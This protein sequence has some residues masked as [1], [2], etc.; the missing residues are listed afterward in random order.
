[1]NDIPYSTAATAAELQEDMREARPDT[2]DKSALAIS[3]CIWAGYFVL[4]NVLSY[5][6]SDRQHV[7]GMLMVGRA[8]ICGT[9]I[10]LCL[11]MHLWLRRRSDN[12]PWLLLFEA[13]CL[14][15][16][17]ST[18]LVVVGQLGFRFF[19]DYYSYYPA[20]WMNPYY[21]GWAFQSHL[22]LFVTWCALYVGAVTILWVRRQEAQLAAAQ[23]AAHRAQLLALR[24]QI[25]PHF[26]FNTLNTLAGLIV[27][28]RKEESE[29]IVLDLSRFL[30]H[31]L[32]KTPTELVPL[33]DEVGVLRMY[34][35]IERARF[36]DRLQ[37][38]YDVP[39][40]CGRALVPSLVLLPFAENSIKHAL[41]NSEDGI[42]I[43][44]GARREGGMLRVWLEDGGRGESHAPDGLGIGLSNVRQQLQALY[45]P[46][47]RL[48]AGPTGDGWRNEIAI[49]WQ[50]AA[51]A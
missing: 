44:V 45:G 25:N 21:M 24:L 14:S 51:K 42:H 32:A 46:Q 47:G 29:R 33:A 36:H 11:L 1:M 10:V 15:A 34:L 37:V 7:I 39:E 12:R 20:E 30:R 23:A 48:R 13:I 27:L 22:W 40:E 17:A 26:L 18:V 2:L 31:T 19:T 5:M 41:G 4:A 43:R 38:S 3:V 50:E 35:D 8:V 16:V 9:A 6:Y 49:P 28:G